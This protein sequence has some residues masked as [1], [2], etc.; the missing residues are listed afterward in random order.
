MDYTS[1]LEIAKTAS[2]EAG[3]AILEV[4]NSDDK[5]VEKK[6]DDSPLTRADKNAHN[7]IE[8]HLLETQ[9]PILSEEGASIP[10]EE[11]KSWDSF[12]MVD[13][14]DGTKEFIKRNGEFT[15]NIALI[16]DGKPVLGVVYVP[17]TEELYW[18]N[19]LEEKAF[20]KTGNSASV[21]LSNKS[22]RSSR[23]SVT[24]GHR[25][26]MSGKDG[27]VV[28]IVCSRSHMNDETHL[29]MQQFEGTEEVSMG[30][31]LKFLKIAEGVADIYPRFGPTMEWDTA[32]AHGVLA[33]CGYHIKE[34]E[35]YSELGYNKENL[36]NPHFVAF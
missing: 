9:I 6:E 18:G 35:E 16:K 12:W 21:E 15:V 11:R 25:A 26:R 33:S 3:L 22:H 27:A 29:F 5:G 31:S 32:A 13:P 36:L 1:L 34:A 7:V 8:K 10:F 23:W 2:I 30:S 4:Y 19:V 28:K 20:K 24:G 14:L 17:V